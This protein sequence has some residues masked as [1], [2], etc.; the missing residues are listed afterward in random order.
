VAAAARWS[1]NRSRTDLLVDIGLGRK[2][3][4]IVAKRLAQLM[5]ER[6]ARPDAVTL[7]LG[8]FGQRRQWP[9]RRRAW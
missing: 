9:R 4:T 1:G 2:I 3:A 7:T 5:A 8:R 6:G